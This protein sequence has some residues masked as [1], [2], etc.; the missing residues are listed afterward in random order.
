[1]RE[2]LGGKGA[3]L[4]EM[5]SIGVRVPPGFTITT[6]VCSKFDEQKKIPDEVM[7]EVWKNMAVLEDIMQAKFG[8][9]D[10]RALLV[11]VRSGAAVSM[12]GMM[13]TILNLGLNDKSVVAFAKATNNPRFAWDSY[14]RLLQMFGNVVMEVNSKNFEQVLEAQKKKQ[15]VEF[16][17]DLTVES[18]QAVVEGYKEVIK[19]ETGKDFP[20][21]AKDQLIMAIEAVFKSW[22]NERAIYYRKMNKI[23]GLLGTAVNVQTMVFGNMNEKSGTGVAFSR[24]PSTGENH[25]FGEFLI[26]AQGEDVVAG[27]RTPQTIDQMKESFPECYA[28][29]EKIYHILEQH[30]KEMQDMEFTIQ[31]NVLYMLQTRTGKRSARAAVKIAVDMVA[32][33][34]IDKK[35]ALTRVAPEQ[36][37]QLMHPQVCPDAKKQSKLLGKGIAASPGAAVG[38][39]VFNNESAVEMKKQGHNVI[40]V[41]SETSPEDLIGM[42]AAVGILTSTG[43]KTSHAAVVARTMGKTCVAGCGSAKVLE[44]EGILEMAGERLKEGDV[45]TLDGTEGE[46]YLGEVKTIPPTIT[47]DFETFISWEKEFRKIGIRA[48]ADTPLDAQ[49][50]IEFGAEGIG[51]C[52]TEH[53]FFEKSRITAVREMILSKDY[54]GRIKALEKIKPYQKQDFVDMFLI[55][56][57]RPITI[58]LLDPPLHEFLPKEEEDIKA[59]ADDMKVSVK[60]LKAKIAELHEANPMMG[61]RGCR[62]GIT[63][64]EITKMQAEAIFEAAYEVVTKHKK[65]VRPEVMIPLIATRQE[66]EHQMKIIRETAERILGQSEESKKVDYKIGTM[67]ETPRACIVAGEIAKGGAEFFSFGSNDLTQMTFGFSR[68]DSGKYLAEYEQ[69]G[70]VPENPFQAIDQEGVGWLMRKAVEDGRKEKP[71]LKIGICGEH[72]GEHSSIDF[73]YRIGLD[74]V[75]CSPFRIIVARLAAAQASIKHSK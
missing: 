39:I 17:Q 2:L 22:N 54:E 9:E 52:R 40:L 26:N 49:R 72:G 8:A 65:V 30:Y 53:M 28:E 5:A 32:E 57:G 58:R 19:K 60:E 31:D 15:G 44:D 18:L 13:D 7:E 33:G 14:R 46:V 61:H 37:D 50:A 11:S 55:M 3:G 20:Q 42:A 47:K 70:I 43:G 41:R 56:D 10:G 1:M 66:F 38:K 62:L 16:D 29:F 63:F 34:L 64:S 35:T 71:D 4:A 48:N 25:L 24:N 74:Y 23:T 69:I 59:I 67:I 75:S 68:D 12:P 45:I 27:I 36:L 6:E 21:S 51:L 73:C